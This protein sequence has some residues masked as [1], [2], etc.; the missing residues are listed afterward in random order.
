MG[1]RNLCFSKSWSSSSRS[2][3]CEDP[4]FSMSC[5]LPCALGWKNQDALC[6]DDASCL[7]STVLDSSRTSKEMPSHPIAFF[8][9]LDVLPP[10]CY[11]PPF[12]NILLLPFFAMSSFP[13]PGNVAEAKYESLYEYG[14]CLI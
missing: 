6:P 13:I 14:Q 1:P 3:K 5:S 4:L 2:V 10:E 12:K 11:F 9:C 7:P 8:C